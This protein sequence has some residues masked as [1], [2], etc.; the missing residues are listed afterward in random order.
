MNHQL[1]I[2]PCPNDTF[3]FYALLHDLVDTEGDSFDVH[4]EDIETLNSI[5]LRGDGD[6]VKASIA[7]AHSIDYNLL[8]SGAALGRG[9]GPIVVRRTNTAPDAPKTA[10]LP[11]EH[12][13]ANLLF[14]RYFDDYQRSYTVFSEIA[15]RIRNEQATLGVLIHEGR[16]TY[17]DQGLELVADLGQMWEKETSLPL[18][19]GGIFALKSLDSEKL[20]RIIRRSVEWALANPLAPLDFVRAHAQELSC[21]VMQQHIN[22]FVNEFTVDLG[23]QGRRAVATI[24][25]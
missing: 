13:T 6:V 2:S 21:D 10:L 5:A 3:A 14:S 19:L 25:A 9:N 17:A 22:L 24:T 16:F 20:S 8:S 23:E 11:G 1:Y 4:F 7:V 18:P 12:T 15:P